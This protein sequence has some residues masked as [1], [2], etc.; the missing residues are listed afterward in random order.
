MEIKLPFNSSAPGN[1]ALRSI[2][3]RASFVMANARRGLFNVWFSWRDCGVLN[4]SIAT[5]YKAQ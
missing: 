4:S 2:A 3:K 1:L 5:S